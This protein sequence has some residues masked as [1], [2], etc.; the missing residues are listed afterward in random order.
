ML[1]TYLFF[2]S[3]RFYWKDIPS[4]MWDS[5]KNLKKEC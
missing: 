5:K 1:I 3:K 2:I 4:I